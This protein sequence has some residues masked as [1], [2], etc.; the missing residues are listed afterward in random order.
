MTLHD[1]DGREI[2]RGSRAQEVTEEE[3]EHGAWRANGRAP[4]R[5]G[6]TVLA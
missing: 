4:E 1:D 6:A 3:S 2:A 5:D